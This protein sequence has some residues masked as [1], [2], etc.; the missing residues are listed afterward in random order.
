MP[1]IES[2]YCFNPFP[3]KPWF[4]RVCRT[5][6]W[7]HCGKSRIRLY[8]AISSFPT[9]FSTLLEKFPPFSSNLKLSSANSF[10]LEPSKIC[11]LE[12][13]KSL[14]GSVPLAYWAIIIL[15]LY[16]AIICYCE[17]LLTLKKLI[18]F[19][20]STGHRPASMDCTHHIDG[21]V[22]QYP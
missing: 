5:S 21:W 12:R 9:V 6:L 20:S 10:S 2:I 7:K 22:Q 13:V 15:I 18:G 8:R 3:N 11:C 16:L 4:L 14:R 17:T 1:F 19:I